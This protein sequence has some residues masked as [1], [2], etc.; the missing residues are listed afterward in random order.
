MADPLLNPFFA[1]T[2]LNRLKGRQVEFFGEALGGPMRY[3]GGTM[4]AVHLGR[5]IEKE[6]FERVAEHLV[7]SLTAAGVPEDT[8]GE[9]V[10]VVAP[11]ADDISPAR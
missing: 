3:E 2:N 11:L 8:V 1:G 9:I 4:K 6:H 5:G 10:S 7:A